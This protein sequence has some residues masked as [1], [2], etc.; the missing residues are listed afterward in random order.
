MTEKPIYNKIIILVDAV[1]L[2]YACIAISHLL[3]KP[4]IEEEFSSKRPIIINGQHARNEEEI[5]FLLSAYRMGDTVL[6]ETSANTGVHFVRVEKYYPVSHVLFDVFI[7]VLIFGL[8]LFVYL[9]RPKH[10]ASPIFHLA[11]SVFAAAIIGTKTM[12]T[13]PPMG[14]GYSLCIIFFIVY[15]I[16]PVLFIHFTYVFPVIQWKKFSKYLPWLYFL[17]VIIACRH[18]SLYLEAARLHTITLYRAT[19]TASMIQNGF[20]FFF[21]LFGVAHFVYSYKTA[22]STTL[23][24]KIRWMLY[25]LLLGPAPF[26]FLWAL[27]NAIG[28]SPWIPEFGFKFFLLIIPVTFAISILK[29]QVMDIELFINRS[30]VYAIV[31]SI[32]L[33]AYLGIV[34]VTVKYLVTFTTQTSLIVSTVT[35]VIIAF[36][37]EPARR[38]VQRFVDYYFFRV[39]YDFRQIQHNFVEEIKQCL[40]VKQIA[41][42]I[43]HRTDDILSLDRIGFFKVEENDHQLE[44]IAHKNFDYLEKFFHFETKNLVKCPELPFALAEKIEPGVPVETSDI[45]IL[46]QWKIDIL[47]PMITERCSLIGLIALGEKKSGMRFT[48][49]DIDLLNTVATQAGL[50]MERI[51]LQQKLLLEQAETQR[52][53]ELNKL[54]SYFVSSVSHDLK[55][56]LTSIKM[57]AELLRTRK[58]ISKSDTTEYLEIIEG[59]SERLTRLINNVLDFSRIER[60]VKEYHFAEIELNSLVKN[61]LKSLRYLFKIEKCTVIDHFCDKECILNADK[62]AVT[63]ALINLISNAIKYSHDEKEITVSIAQQNGFVTLQVADHGIGIPSEDIPHIFEPFYRAK[64]R[65]THGAGGAGLGLAIVKHIMDAHNGKVEVRSTHGKGSLFTLIFPHSLEINNETNSHS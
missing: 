7:V 14:L 57:F 61:V 22:I 18:A 33:I 55:T 40:N 31:I 29:Y 12:Y 16:I 63:E 17:A 6:V 37:F 30:T 64:E 56:P 11:C 5:E 2:F 60:G 53:E 52:L 45:E 46:H 39:Q 9:K 19:M 23:K 26:I 65:K 15:T 36:L 1:F 28:Y 50:T 25:S 58:N 32:G 44:V 41:E 35:A 8:G 20:V 51:E 48:S 24:R 59:E 62:D 10:Q 42:C 49:E 21:L 34:S 54:K 47:F 38:R 27:P 43:V 13:I 3:N 4:Y